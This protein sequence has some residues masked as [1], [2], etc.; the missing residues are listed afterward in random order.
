MT[1][2]VR[3][4]ANR[5]GTVGVWTFEAERMP[6]AAERDYARAVES[7]GFKT[8]WLPE[9][10]GS[11]EAFAHASLVLAATKTLIVATGIAPTAFSWD[12]A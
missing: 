6:A 8:L 5:L 1:E 7:L 9:S 10:L 3:E 4:W 11:K 12:S 2:A